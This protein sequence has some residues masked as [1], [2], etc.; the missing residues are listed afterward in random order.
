MSDTETGRDNDGEKSQKR[1]LPSWMSS[2]GSK[3]HGMKPKDEG[4]DG[5][6]KQT[7]GLSK[8]KKQEKVLVT[9][10]S[11]TTDF[12]KLLEGV[13][14]VLSGF[15]NPERST[16]RSQALA[17]GAIYQP[18][19]NSDSTLL[20][21]AFPNTPK[22][23]Q[24]ESDSGTIV[25]KE[26]ITECYTQK[27]L[28]G[29][30][31]YLMHL[32]KPWR[33]ISSSPQE[34]NQEKKEPLP[35]KPQ[36]QV[37]KK[38]ETRGSTSASLKSR[39]SGASATERFP[40]SEVKKW[41]MADLTQTISWLESQEEKPEPGE[42]KR[43][44]AEGILTCLQDAIDSLEQNRGVGTVTEQWSFVPR[45]VKELGKIEASWENRNSS[46]SKEDLC[47]LA[48]EWKEMYETELKKRGQEESSTINEKGKAGRR[49][50]ATSRETSGY[51]SDETVEMTE[52]EIELA[53]Q[54]VASGSC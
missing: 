7:H 3:S 34:T 53:Y 21:C 32:G 49:N 2:S 24:V 22:F 45:V 41:A 43:V 40:P 47:R 1:N 54:K 10:C 28:V 50:A 29:I 18:D 39:S 31:Q 6:D 37:E 33:K 25:S 52:E 11:S 46:G 42:I 8:E 23:R 14:F 51:D 36:K 20:V 9:P 19:W 27:K 26:W 13:V 35:K 16:L 15:V 30:E 17:M 4:E 44:A 48:K 5:K 12:T 38:S